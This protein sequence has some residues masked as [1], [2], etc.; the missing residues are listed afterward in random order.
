MSRRWGGVLGQLQNQSIGQQSMTLRGFVASSSSSN[1]A[2]KKSFISNSG[3]NLNYLLANPGIRRLFSTN[4]PKKKSK[5]FL[6]QFS[7][8]IFFRKESLKCSFYI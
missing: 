6:V 1:A 3:A 2:F 4:S 8:V 5:F 7:K